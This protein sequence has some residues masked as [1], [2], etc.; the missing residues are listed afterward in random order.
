MNKP[1][2]EKFILE[3]EDISSCIYM[4]CS[5]LEVDTDG[6]YA[7]AARGSWRHL[8]RVIADMRRK[9]EARK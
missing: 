3:L 8:D 1:E 5:V 2:F 4:L 7:D 6:M 9:L